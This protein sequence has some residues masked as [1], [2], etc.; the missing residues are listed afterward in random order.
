MPATG[1]IDAPVLRS[2][3]RH[4]LTIKKC[5]DQQGGKVMRYGYDTMM[6]WE[7]RYLSLIDN[8]HVLATTSLAARQSRAVA[9]RSAHGTVVVHGLG[10]GIFLRHVITLP[11]VS[12]V[13]AVDADWNVLSLNEDGVR[14]K[15][16]GDKVEFIHGHPIDLTRGTLATKYGHLDTVDFLYVDTW[17][18]D[19]DMGYHRV[20]EVRDAVE[21]LFPFVTWFHG[22]E[23]AMVDWMRNHRSPPLWDLS[24]MSL[25][26]FDEWCIH[27]GMT[28]G[29]RSNAYLDHAKT[30]WS[31]QRTRRDHDAF[32]SVGKTRKPGPRWYARSMYVNCEGRTRT[33]EVWMY[34][35]SE[36][37]ARCLACRVLED[38]FGMAKLLDMRLE[39]MG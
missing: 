9:A 35:A 36:H 19:Y 34:A 10:L 5:A 1:P 22:Q 17:S 26:H 24:R 20:Q 4:D 37:V 14:G 23:I 8:G 11:E 39:V 29:H 30:C 33:D 7:D 32:R 2:G 25:D 6:C 15:C 12:R 16:G 31:V 21:G 18:P 28:L 13:F 27:V 3:T 38:D